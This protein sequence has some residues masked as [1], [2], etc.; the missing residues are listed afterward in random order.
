MRS[1]VFAKRVPDTAARIRI[2]D[3][4]SHVQ[5][6]GVEFVTSPYDEYAL[7]AAVQIKEDE[8][9][10]EVVV[11]SLGGDS[12]EKTLRDCL[13]KG[14][15]RGIHLKS[16]A[17]NW[18]PFSTGEAFANLLEDMEFDAAWFGIH[19]VDDDAYQV[20]QIVAALLDLPVATFVTDVEVDGDQIICQ[21]ETE[22]GVQTVTLDTP[23]V[24]S[25][26]KGLADP[27]Y[28]KLPDIMDAKK[29]EIDVRSCN[30]PEP[31][32][33]TDQLEPPPERPP[34]EILGEGVDA[35]PELIRVLREEEGFI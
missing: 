9:D 19:A 18:D 21:R 13:A 26:E 12:V 27:R 7:E 31:T 23:C 6:E 3:D 29:K 4:Q 34:G 1:V 11:A 8:D 35:V 22:N 33:I 5:T 32:L 20:P 16:D 30:D 17:E 2:S 10:G 15:D 28:A 25:A 14:G 24:I